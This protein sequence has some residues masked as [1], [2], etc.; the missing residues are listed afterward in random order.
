[1]TLDSFMLGTD[2]AVNATSGVPRL[3][4]LLSVSKNIKTPTMFIHLKDD[5]SKIDIPD[6]DTKNEAL[7]EEYKRNLLM[8]K[9][10]LVIRLCDIV[11]KRKYIGMIIH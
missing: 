1:M 8:L 2:A 5:I 3:K 11:Y 6:L 10:I 7:I 9:I 4:E